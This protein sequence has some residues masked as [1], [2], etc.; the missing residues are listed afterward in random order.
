MVKPATPPLKIPGAWLLDWGG[1]QR[2]LVSDEPMSLIRERTAAVGGH[3]TL[4]RGGDRSAEIFQ[5]LAMPLLTLHQRLKTA[6]DPH[7]I[8]NLGRMYS[9]L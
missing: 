3:V 1:A 4:F 8:F 7:G 2:W 5:P 9:G 6:F